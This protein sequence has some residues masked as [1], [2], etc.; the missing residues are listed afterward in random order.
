MEYKKN[1]DGTDELDAQGNPIP[2]DNTDDKEKE[3]AKVIANLTEEIK[4]ERIKRSVAEALLEENKKNVPPAPE[5]P[6]TDDEKLEALVDKKLKE[7]E[8]SNA[9]ANKK[10]AF[11][12]FVTENKEF[13][14]DNDPTGLRRDA[15]QKKV[16]QF[17]TEGLATVEEFLSVIGDAKTLLLG[18]DTTI[19]TSKDK[20][21]DSFPTPKGDPAG[22]RNEELTPKEL[23]LAQMPGQSKDKILKLKAKNPEYLETLLEFV[24]D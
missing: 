8:A 13:H 6:L 2:V 7:K 11:E 19:E 15:L 22:K 10:T 12:K 5:K 9:V 3:A 18:N 1:A 17:N 20:K 4:Q 16:N 23:K 14:P 24:R 21:L